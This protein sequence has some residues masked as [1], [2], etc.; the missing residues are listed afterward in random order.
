MRQTPQRPNELLTIREAAKRLRCSAT[1]VYSLIDR[2]ALP[3][4]RVGN[5]KGYRIDP[6]DLDSFVQ[7]RKQAK[8]GTPNNGVPPRPRLKHIKI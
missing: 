4:V 8:Q 6:C 1:N 3:F 5:A 7:Q 2:G